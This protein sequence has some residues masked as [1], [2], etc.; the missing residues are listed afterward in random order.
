MHR[1]RHDGNRPGVSNDFQRKQRFFI[2]GNSFSNDEIHS[3]I[4]RPSHLFLKHSSSNL[5]AVGIV[6]CKNVARTMFEEQV[7]WGYGE[8]WGLGWS[9][10]VGMDR[11]VAVAPGNVSESLKYL[12]FE[13]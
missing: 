1:Q 13:T 10:P 11:Y 4:N 9:G 2:K 12:D 3:G 6:R 7:G 8:D 5:F